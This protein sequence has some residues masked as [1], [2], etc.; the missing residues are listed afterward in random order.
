MYGL[1]C[2]S[3][4]RLVAYPQG[5]AYLVHTRAPTAPD[6][7]QSEAFQVRR[8][9]HLELPNT[10]QQ[11]FGILKAETASLLI[12][13]SKHTHHN[14][15]VNEHTMSGLEPPIPA[16][17]VES[18]ATD[19][20]ASGRPASPA[21]TVVLTKSWTRWRRFVGL[22]LLAVTV[23]LWTASNFL[24]SVRLMML[25]DGTEHG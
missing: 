22:L 2:H 1:F 19:G 6:L 17:A 5:S 12:R 18:F 10:W 4:D 8:A 16:I 15:R 14:S 11:Q 7:S 13:W 25:G 21:S 20:A 3:R 9:Y 23:V 24:A